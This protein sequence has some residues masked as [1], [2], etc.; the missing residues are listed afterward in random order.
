MVL[1]SQYTCQLMLQKGTANKLSIAL[2]NP[3]SMQ[4][5]DIMLP[6]STE[7]ALTIFSSDSFS[8][9]TQEKKYSMVKIHSVQETNL[10]SFQMRK[11]FLK[12][13]LHKDLNA[14]IK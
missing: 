12:Q 3:N 10:L 13:G 5:S 9:K 4:R 6:Y 1:Q 8:D 2:A 14:G 11:Y 7:T